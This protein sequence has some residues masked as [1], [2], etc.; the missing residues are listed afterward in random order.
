MSVIFE[1]GKSYTLLMSSK[2]NSAVKIAAANLQK[3][4]KAVLQA[5]LQIV[6]E[7]AVTDFKANRVKDYDIIL[8][9]MGQ[10]RF[11]DAIVSQNVIPTWG[12]EGDNGKFHKEGYVLAEQE[13]ALIIT[14]TDRRGTVYGIYELSRQMGVSPWYFFA[15][16]PIKKK[17]EF[18]IAKNYHKSS[19]PS[20]EYRGIFIN[21]EEELE[22]WSK[23]H[24]SDDTIGPETYKHIFELLLRLKANFIWPAM[25]VNSFNVN[26]ENGRLADSMGIVVGTSHCDMLMR[27][28]NREWNQWVQKKGYEGLKYDF[29]IPGENRERLIEYWQESVEQ[30][31]DFEVCYTVGMRG[32]HD[33]G[34]MTERIDRKDITPEEK[35]KEKTKLLENIIEIQ[36]GIISCTLGD[37]KGKK[38]LQSFVPYKEVMAMYDNGLKV[39]DN[40]TTIWVDDNFG[41]MRRYPNAEERKRSGG[42]GL[43]YHA[44][45][46]AHPGMSYLFFNSIPLAHIHNELRKSYESGIR[47]MWVL[48]VGA[49]KPIEQEID[50]FTNYAWNVGKENGDIM[51]VKEYLEEWADYTFSGGFGRTIADICIKFARISNVRKV[52]HMRFD[53]FSQTAYGDEAIRRLNDYKRLVKKANTIY[54]KLPEEEKAA[55][56]EF[57]LMK[58]QAAYYIYASFYCADRSNLCFEQGKLQAADMYYKKAYKFDSYKRRLIEYYNKKLVDGKWD[59]ILTPENYPPPRTALFPPARP[60]LRIEGKPEMKVFL[61]KG[62]DTTADNELV[63]SKYGVEYKWFEVAN[64][65]KGSFNYEAEAPDWIWLSETSGTVPEENRILVKISDIGKHQ[66]EC[67]VIKINNLDDNKCFEINVKVEEEHYSRDVQ[68]Y[69]EADGY[70]SIPCT[71]YDFNYNNA[72]GEYNV[73]SH[74]GRHE[75]SMLE[76]DTAD[77][78][79]LEGDVSENPYVE[80][81]FNNYTEGSFDVEFYRFMTLNSKGRIRFAVSIDGNEPVVLESPINDEW[82]GN[83]RDSVMDNVDKVMYTL[84]F[85]EAGE[86]RLCIYMIDNYVAFSKVV[87]Y[88]KGFLRSNLGP[89]LSK[90][91]LFDFHRR[92][93]EKPNELIS[94]EEEYFEKVCDEIYSVS[95]EELANRSTCYAALKQWRGSLANEVI[96]KELPE[97]GTKKN[98]LNAQNEKDIP[99]SFGMGMFVEENG[100]LA[101]EAEC[102]LEE[103]EY[104]FT[105]EGTEKPGI[106]W[107]HS[108]AETCGQTGL[109][110]YIREK[111]I[112]WTEPLGAPS[113]HYKVKINNPGRYCVWMLIKFDTLTKGTCFVGVDDYIQPLEEQYMKGSVFAYCAEQ[114][115]RWTAITE[116]ELAEGEHTLSIYASRSDFRIDRIWLTN[117]DELPPDD[118]E[119][120]DSFR[121]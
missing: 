1:K 41:Y 85:L 83:W 6:D 87:I 113:L 99:A 86:H 72:K 103:S 111:G 25:H 61:W 96:I 95:A 53:I 74:L 66:G 89:Q 36:R 70:I 88:T 54:T 21:D 42:H 79:A 110:M 108:D 34:F 12:I 104:A 107:I 18:V 98:Y 49:L 67:G 29:T 50:F 10:S 48:N 76:A 8:G 117:E 94:L 71:K 3:D 105:K 97:A 121:K 100:R 51:D 109:A 65:G 118:F 7:S 114:I 55:F 23:K 92:G 32:I 52:E 5:D 22:V 43:Y 47:K 115:W 11:I 28:N 58:L 91:T 82:K 56:F 26:V 106:K 17:E 81:I 45:Y 77:L 14:G 38:A 39:P 37:E 75:G 102:V 116:I 19:Y 84:P 30:N 57:V 9:T 64:M 59:G 40:I 80:Y 33:S 120:K 46:W 27:S 112:R 31:K 93:D 69:L 15:D 119:W 4:F 13:G 60:A 16:V 20:V 63:F 78:N 90:H 24:T 73:I 68:G 2:E 62:T 35:Q 101:L 44:S